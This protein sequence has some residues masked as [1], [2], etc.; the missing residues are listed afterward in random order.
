MSRSFGASATVALLLAGVVMACSSEPA[1]PHNGVNDVHAA[2]Q[3]RASWK[4]DTSEKC[5][6]CYASAPLPACGCELFKD[7]GGLCADQGAA[8]TAEPTC[9]P[10]L[11][12][13]VGACP[14][15]D[16]ACIDGCYAQADACRRVS[17]AVDGCVTDVCAQYCE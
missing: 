4:H 5:V 12:G 2:C 13:C 10:T 6:N 8:R 7:F 11:N 1:A 14:K 9:D 17:A 15:T 3:V 16:C